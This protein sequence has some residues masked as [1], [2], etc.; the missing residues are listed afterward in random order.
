MSRFPINWSP[1][2]CKPLHPGIGSAL[3]TVTKHHVCQAQLCS[4]HALRPFVHL[5]II[6]SGKYFFRQRFSERLK[7]AKLLLPFPLNSGVGNK[8]NIALLLLFCPLLF[9]TAGFI[10]NFPCNP[11]LASVGL[12]S[13]GDDGMSSGSLSGRNLRLINGKHAR[14]QGSRDAPASQGCRCLCRAPRPCAV[15]KQLPKTCP[16]PL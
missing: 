14:L 8:S 6:S 5:L 4:K 15:L 11:Q 3:A 7:H 9:S 16:Y 12:Q 10:F 2:I 13:L 1:T